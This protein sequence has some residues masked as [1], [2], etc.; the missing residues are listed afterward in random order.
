MNKL[1]KETEEFLHNC[2][3][4]VYYR[5]EKARNFADVSCPYESIIARS[6]LDEDVVKEAEEKLF[7]T[8]ENTKL[9]ENMIRM[10]TPI[11][12]GAYDNYM[13]GIK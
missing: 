13:K 2:Q 8:P 1:V 7:T 4:I 10:F 3:V 12:E 9:A 11:L 6:A 5:S